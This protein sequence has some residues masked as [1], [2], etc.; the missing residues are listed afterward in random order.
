M[1][2]PRL[3]ERAL[4]HLNLDDDDDSRDDDT[5]RDDDDDDDHH[6]SR[7]ARDDVVARAYHRA[8]SRPCPSCGDYFVK[9]SARRDASQCERCDARPRGA[10]PRVLIM[11]PVWC[12]RDDDD[13]HRRL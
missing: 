4:A 3:L 11:C 13:D 12:V 1:D 10:V 2:E 6:A 7:A 8:I 5:A 9:T